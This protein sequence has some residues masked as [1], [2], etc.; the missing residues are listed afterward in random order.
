MIVKEVLLLPVKYNR[1]QLADGVYLSEIRDDKFKTNFVAVQ[2]VSDFEPSQ[3][4]ARALLPNILSVSNAE[5]PTREALN[6]KLASLYDATFSDSEKIVGNNYVTTFLV[7]CIADRY[8]IDGEKV[9]AELVKVLL[10]AIFS[11]KTENGA[12]DS[13]EFSLLKQELLDEIDSEINNK[14]SYAL[15]QATSK[16][17]YRGEKLG[18]VIYGERKDAQT[19]TNEQVFGLYKSFL[20]DSHIEIYVGC[21][22]DVSDA[23]KMLEDAFSAIPRGNVHKPKYYVPSQI[24]PQT[25]KMSENMDIKQTRLVMAYKSP[26]CDLYAAKLLAALFGLIP[27]SKLFMNV[28]EKMSLCYSCSSIFAEYSNTLLV[29]S[30]IDDKNLEKTTD[31]INEQFSLLCGGDITEKELAETK[32]MITGAFRSNYDSML[33]LISWYMV[34]CRRGSCY[35]PNEVIDKLN[36]VTREDI[37]SAANSFRLDSVYALRP[38]SGE[39][40][41]NEQ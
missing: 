9:T 13:K 14:G 16:L 3:T 22:E 39:E 36:A 15:K 23:V 12:F 18:A 8:T 41:H 17:I 40:E 21:S 29:E 31:A 7:G 30:G 34:Q 28:R 11:P 38:T 10:S 33:S 25:E 35:T 5:Y 20:A 24:K 32:L 27:T 1:K 26:K 6:M 19:V 2:F 4:P 37:I